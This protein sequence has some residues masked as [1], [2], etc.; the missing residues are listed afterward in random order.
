MREEKLSAEEAARDLV[1]SLNKNFEGAPYYT[2]EVAHHQ[3]R[4]IK[5]I[6]SK[7][8]EQGKQEAEQRIWK[9]LERHQY[10]DGV[11][12]S[13]GQRVG[14]VIELHS[15]DIKQIIFGGGDE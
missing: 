11:L 4:V 9:E 5:A 12:R 7:G 8:Y 3:Q 6:Y 13:S 2:P 1:T 15:N 14:P 10:D